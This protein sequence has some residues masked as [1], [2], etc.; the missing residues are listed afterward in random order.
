[1]I[2]VKLALTKKKLSDILQRIDEIDP[3]MEIEDYFQSL[4]DTDLYSNKLKELNDDELKNVIDEMI[5]FAL[6]NFKSDRSFKANELYAKAFEE[7]WT[8]LSPSTRKSL[9]R[10]LRSAINEHWDEADAGDWVIEFYERNINNAALYR[11]TEK[12]PL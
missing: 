1:M 4:A 2:E 11:V 12:V 7:P 6:K 5:S 10:R 3:Q 8:K 9:G